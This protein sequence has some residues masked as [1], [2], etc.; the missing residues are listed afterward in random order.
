MTM[1]IKKEWFSLVW[2]KK[3]IEKHLSDGLIL[4]AALLNTEIIQQIIGILDIKNDP[5]VKYVE[6]PAGIN[7]VKNLVTKD[8]DYVGF[9]LY[10]ILLDEL[11]QV[12]DK[13]DILPPKSTF[14][15]PRLR[16]GLIIMDH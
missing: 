15:Q 7:A 9:C 2:R 11:M 3:I 16:N 5:R 12:S 4:D 13:G 1:L 8:D 10:P 6:G 14:F